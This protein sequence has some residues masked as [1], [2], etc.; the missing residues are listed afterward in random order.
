VSWNYGLKVPVHLWN[1]AAHLIAF[2]TALGYL[3]HVYEQNTG[4][5]QGNNVSPFL[6][7]FVLMAGCLNITRS[8]WDILRDDEL[9]L[10]LGFP[11]ALFGVVVVGLG[12]KQGSLGGT[13]NTMRDLAGW[14]IMAGLTAV[15]LTLWQWISRVFFSAGHKEQPKQV[16]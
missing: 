1:M 6:A 4:D 8:L 15:F 7:M 5:Y 2:A 3:D 13:S 9:S 16:A 12:A 11:A 14:A 10:V